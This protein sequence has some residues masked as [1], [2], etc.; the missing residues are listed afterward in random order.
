MLHCICNVC[1]M[2]K[3]NADISHKFIISLFIHIYTQT[4]IRFSQRI[5]LKTK[6]FRIIRE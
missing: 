1:Q 5:R 4:C 2:I 6:I 3:A